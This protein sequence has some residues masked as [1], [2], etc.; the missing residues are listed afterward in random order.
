MSHVTLRFHNTMLKIKVC[1]RNSNGYFSANFRL[2]KYN[3]FLNLQISCQ[4]FFLHKKFKV[5]SLH[6]KFIKLNFD[7]N[8]ITTGFFFLD[9]CNGCI[10]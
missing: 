9:A 1:F 6:L 2:Q 3:I 8:Q 10:L 7:E 4:Y 5:F